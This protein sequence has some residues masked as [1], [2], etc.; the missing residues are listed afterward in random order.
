MKRLIDSFGFKRETFFQVFSNFSWLM[1]DQFL[2]IVVGFFVSVIFIRKF[3]V[4]EYGAFNYA[5]AFISFFTA[6]A[7]LGLDQ[8]VIKELVSK[9]ESRGKILTTSLVMRLASSLFSAVLA[10]IIISALRPN[11]GLIFN[12]VLAFSL[13]FVFQSFYVFDLWFQSKVQSK[14]SVIAKDIGFVIS[15]GLKVFL[16]NINAP[17]IYL[18]Y[19]F[20]FEFLITSV[21]LWIFF[22]KKSKDNQMVVDWKMGKE[23]LKD[24]WPL[25]LSGLAIFLYMRLNQILLGNI[26]G[27]KEVG[28]YSLAVMFSE[29]WYFV[30]MAICTSVFPSLIKYKN[31]DEN[32]YKTRIK[33]FTRFLFGLGVVAGIFASIFGKIFIV[34]VYGEKY[35]QSADILSILIWSGIA[36]SMGLVSGQLLIIDK[37]TKLAFIRTAIGALGNII[38]GLVLIPSFGV[39]GAAISTLFGYF[40]STY[41]VFFFKDGRRSNMVLLN[42]WK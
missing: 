31:L 40:M 16:L 27:D 6:I 3:T 9:S 32:L 12:M 19:L 38:F 26:L 18:A 10:L 25:I 23:M 36:V 42:F 15:I 34:F 35:V 28:V 33:Q 8:I 14:Y 30:P 13:S 22:R 2:R 1:F 29:F 5:L 37:L 20:S 11:N 41:S 24:S 39:Y 7:G 17:I 4:E 21:G